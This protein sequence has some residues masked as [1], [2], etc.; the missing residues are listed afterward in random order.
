MNALSH[1]LRKQIAMGF[2]P[3]FIMGMYPPQFSYEPIE[4]NL[5]QVWADTQAINLYYHVP[6]CQWKCSFCTFF[7]IVSNSDHEYGKY[8]S[9]LNEQFAY[10]K[11]L[12]NG[13]L[14]IKSVCFGGGTPNVIPVLLYESVF[15]ELARGN[16]VLD[17]ELEPSMEVSPEIITEDY[18]R[19]LPSMGVKRL[20]LGVQSLKSD[21]RESVNRDDNLNIGDIVNSIRRHNLNINIDLINGLIGQNAENFMQ[22]LEEIIK[23]SPETISIY[24]LSGRNSSLFK[25]REYLMTTKERYDLFDI[26]YD[27][28]LNHGYRCESHVKFV[29]LD[30]KS[31]HQQ[32]IYEYQGVETLGIGCGAKSYNSH[33][34]YGLPWYQ[35]RSDAEKL[36]NAYMN[37]MDFQRMPWHGIYMTLD[38]NKRRHMVY[39]FFL[40]ELDIRGYQLRFGSSVFDDFGQELAALQAND[41]IDTLSEDVIVLNQKGRKYTDLVGGLFWSQAMHETFDAVRQKKLNQTLSSKN[42]ASPVD[43]GARSST[44][45]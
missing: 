43:T 34:H 29:K 14:R 42:S 6:F 12:F 26:Y 10:Y 13:P 41:L 16:V 3:G 40:G 30:N 35:K 24:L 15:E 27:Y 38:E 19:S 17:E 32:K 36:I 33:V 21:L 28:L 11:N 23:F 20:S 18:I 22:T 9:R 1:L 39:S 45:P 37:Q 31:T 8:I 7:A 2:W 44:T 5:E 4:V 25:S